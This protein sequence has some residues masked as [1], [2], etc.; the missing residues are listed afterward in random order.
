[1]RKDWDNYFVDIA[2]EVAERST[3]PRL[4]VGAV[5]VKN[6]R[7]KGTGYNGSPRGLEHCDEVGCYLKNNHCIRTIHAEVNCLLEVSP[8]DRENST[9]YVTHMPCPEC[10]KLIITC[11]IKRVVYSEDYKPEINWFEKAP[12][13]EL[14]CLK[15]A[16]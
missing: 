1:M 8:E 11:G 5:L 16:E 3:C 9:L 12:Q 14:I 6:R 7:I 10:Q 4:H 15:R 13:I 2:F